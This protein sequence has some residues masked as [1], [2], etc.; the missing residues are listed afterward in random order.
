M[1]TKRILLMLAFAAALVPGFAQNPGSSREKILSFFKNISEYDSKCSQEKVYLHLDNNA[2][3]FSE[4]IY[5]KAYVVRASTLRFTDL[6]KVLYVELLDDD[7]N[8]VIRKNY[9]ISEGQVSGYLPLDGLL[10]SGFYEVRAFTRAMLNWDGD[11]CFSR[12]IPVY[13]TKDTLGMY[14]SPFMKEK[15]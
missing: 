6:S 2:Y 9:E 15:E 11:Y 7:G 13:E 4:K 1:K 3:F 5:F 14:S 10:R 12:L 8:L